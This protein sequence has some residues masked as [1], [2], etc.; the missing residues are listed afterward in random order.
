LGDTSGAGGLTAREVEVLRL[1]A[2]GL[3]TSETAAELNYS[4]RTIKTVV[5]EIT[6]RLGLRCR[7]QAVSYALRKGLL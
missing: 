6:T 1:L 3:S 2:D 7:A 4:E 5:H